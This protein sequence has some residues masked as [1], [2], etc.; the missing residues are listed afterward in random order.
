MN[1]CYECLKHLSIEMKNCSNC[2]FALLCSESCESLHKQSGCIVQII[3][4]HLLEIQN[5]LN[6]SHI[7][8]ENI[9][10]ENS[11]SSS[12]YSFLSEISSMNSIQL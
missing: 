7:I 4:S 6:E 3:Q 1:V 9:T 10:D 12:K 2:Y 11:N 5:K 8:T